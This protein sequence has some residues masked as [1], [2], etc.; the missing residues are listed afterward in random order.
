MQAPDVDDWSA[1]GIDEKALMEIALSKR[2]A[3]R[4]LLVQC[5]PKTGSSSLAQALRPVGSVHEL[6]MHSVLNITRLRSRPN[7]EQ[8][9]QHWLQARQLRLQG[10][11]DVCTSLALVVADLDDQ[12][13][14]SHGLDRLVLNRSLTPWLHSMVN[15]SFM[16]EANPYRQSWTTAY[17]DFVESVDEELAEMMPSALNHLAAMMNFWIPVWLIYQAQIDRTAISTRAL[18]LTE[19]LNLGIRANV[20]QYEDTYEQAFAAE[21]PELPSLNGQRNHD[22]ECAREIR[23][24]FINE[25]AKNPQS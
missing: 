10:R 17:H 21:I 9:R 6:D 11:V 3:G 5:L 16:H 20:S 8:H 7:F 25:R 14:A 4:N 23:S 13:L 22:R 24:W 1:D 18:I 15:W 19:N 2:E 12:G